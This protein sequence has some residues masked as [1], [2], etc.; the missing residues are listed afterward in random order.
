[1]DLHQQ[2]AAPAAT[3]RAALDPDIAFWANR[4]LANCQK[5]AQA[6]HRREQVQRINRAVAAFA[7]LKPASRSE[8]QP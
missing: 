7:S 4:N 1:M 5:A 6:R 8:V 2:P 3:G